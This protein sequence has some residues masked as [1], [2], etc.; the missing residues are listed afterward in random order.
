MPLADQVIEVPK[1]S[2]RV[3]TQSVTARKARFPLFEPQ[4]STC[5]CRAITE[6]RGGEGSAVCARGGDTS[7]RRWL[8]S[9]PRTSTTGP[10]GDRGRPGQG[11]EREKNYTATLR[12][13][14]SSPL[15]LPPRRLLPSTGEDVGEAPAAR[16]P[17]PLL[18]VLPQE[19]VK[20]RTVPLLH[21]VVPQ[22]VEQ[23][24]D[25]LSPPDFRVGEQVIEVHKIL[26]PPRAARTVLRAPQTVPCFP[27]ERISEQI[28]EQTVDFPVAGGGLQDFRPG[29]SSSSVAHSPAAWL[30]TE[31]ESFQGFYRTFPPEKKVRLTP[32]TWVRECPARARTAPS[33]TR[34]GSAELGCCRWCTGSRAWHPLVPSWVPLPTPEQVQYTGF[35]P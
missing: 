10:H 30:N 33:G 22:T 13:M 28:V 16:R 25:I 21:D 17:A 23:L 11:R 24:V 15:P 18:E 5:R 14:S 29:Q 9:W 1:V 27:L 3:L 8:Q 34:R 2:C 31:D 26:C 35:R 32:G 7:S 19:R 4:W 6:P 20:H 12:K